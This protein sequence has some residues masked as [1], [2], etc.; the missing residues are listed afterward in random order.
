MNQ[1]LIDNCLIVLS[2]VTAILIS[3]FLKRRKAGVVFSTLILFPP[4]LVFLNMWAHTIV[5]SILNVKRYQA[6]SFHY[7]F[8]VYSQLLFGIVFI[9]L[10]GATIHFSKKYISGL[11]NQKR[12]I[13]LANLATTIFFLPVG[14]ITPIG[15]LPV[16]TSIFSSTILF[17][18]NP[19]KEKKINYPATAETNLS[20]IR[21]YS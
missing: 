9:F 5:I 16:L 17:I 2:I 1:V 19:Y 6:G 12:N 3:R 4:L 20:T 11:A 10:S 13:Y 21:T 7:N 15:F 14:F 8:T 18:Y